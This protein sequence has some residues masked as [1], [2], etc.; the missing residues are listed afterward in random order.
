[1]LISNFVTDYQIITCFSCKLHDFY[2]ELSLKFLRYLQ[3]VK[4]YKI[5]NNIIHANTNQNPYKTKNIHTRRS[6]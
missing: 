4:S 3:F 2:F 5:L 6:F 1:M